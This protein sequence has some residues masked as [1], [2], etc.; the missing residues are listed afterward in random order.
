MSVDRV[1]RIAACLMI[2]SGMLSSCVKEVTLDAGDRAVVVECLLS[3]EPGQE[4]SLSFSKGASEDSAMELTEAVATLIDL[5][6]GETVGEF[7]RDAD[8]KWRMDYA[9]IPLHK[10]RLE[11]KVP[12]YD[13]IYAEDTMPVEVPLEQNSKSL[14]SMIM[15]SGSSSSFTLTPGRPWGDS[16]NS[17]TLFIASES[18]AHGRLKRQHF[19]IYGMRWNKTSGKY[20]LADK[21]CAREAGETIDDFNLTGELYE[22]PVAYSNY[23]Y[24]LDGKEYPTY[25]TYYRSF[26]GCPIHRNYLRLQTDINQSASIDVWA[27]I[28]D[29]D[30]AV[31]KMVSAATDEHTYSTRTKNLM[32][33][34]SWITDL[35]GVVMDRFLF[36]ENQEYVPEYSDGYI[37]FVLVSD[38]Y[39]KYTEDALF[40]IR[41][42]GNVSG[43]LS[44]LSIYMRENIYSNINGG[45]GFFAT[46]TRKKGTLIVAPSMVVDFSNPIN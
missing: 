35:D 34:H 8:G 6:A 5:T 22:A 3:N 20:E 42:H 30:A 29:V 39:D 24:R 15:A 38:V 45:V 9:A 46:S 13:L 10:Y 28:Y 36:N 14:Y 31:D 2:I 32:S 40:Q 25:L 4:L 44:E 1:L 21:I 33:D 23:P 18:I 26:N 17:S 43:D 12:G 41:R 19:W 27:N 7:K 11:V 16:H 37:Q